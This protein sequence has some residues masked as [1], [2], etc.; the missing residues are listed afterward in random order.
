LD[1]DQPTEDNETVIVLLTDVP[2]DRA[3]ALLLRNRPGI[4]SRSHP[5][6]GMAR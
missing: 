2:R 5:A 4:T 1:L 3:D 6:P